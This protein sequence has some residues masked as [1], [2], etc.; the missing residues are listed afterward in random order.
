MYTVAHLCQT[1]LGIR[2][3]YLESLD[4]ALRQTTEPVKW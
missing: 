1:I 4:M 2:N 3:I